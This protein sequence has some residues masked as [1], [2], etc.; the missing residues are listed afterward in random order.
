MQSKELILYKTPDG[1]ITI[2]V[3]VE[4]ESVW[5][6]QSQMGLL[7]DKNRRTIGDH[8]KNVF[9]EGELQ[10]EVVCRNFRHTTPHGAMTG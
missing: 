7:F 9:K 4:N 1:D 8:I 10:E 6:S 3:L 2:D 5:L